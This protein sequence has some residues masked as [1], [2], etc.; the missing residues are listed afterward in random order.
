MK[1]EE[2]E[3]EEEVIIYWERYQ[4]P[5]DNTNRSCFY[6]FWLCFFSLIHLFIHSIMKNII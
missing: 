3:E 4:F 1:K 2:E 6:K 5:V